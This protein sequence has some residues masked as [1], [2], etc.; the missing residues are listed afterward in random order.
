MKPSISAMRDNVERLKDYLNKNGIRYT[1]EDFFETFHEYEFR[2]SDEYIVSV[3]PLIN[4]F[5]EK[6]RNSKLEYKIYRYRSSVIVDSP[7]FEF[8]SYKLWEVKMCIDKLQELGIKKGC[9][10]LTKLAMKEA[11]ENDIKKDFE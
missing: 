7:F 6:I 1:F 9:E 10:Y 8:G 3:R 11:M 5:G 2:I 4:N